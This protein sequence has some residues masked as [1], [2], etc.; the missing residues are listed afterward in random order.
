V[1]DYLINP[2]DVD[3]I[4]KILARYQLID[5][6]GDA[7][8]KYLSPETEMEKLQKESMKLQVQ[9]QAREL[10]GDD[11]AYNRDVNDKGKDRLANVALMEGK[12]Q[13]QK[14]PFDLKSVLKEATFEEPLQATFKWATLVGNTP[15]EASHVGLNSILRAIRR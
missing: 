3:T 14:R 15:K 8:I 4:T 11:N 2:T 5:A 7:G 12:R 1:S 10:Y 9:K 6:M 13:L